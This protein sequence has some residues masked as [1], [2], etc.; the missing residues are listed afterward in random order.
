[1]IA[2][3]T[4][5]RSEEARV[6]HR[7]HLAEV[8]A[9]G[10]DDGIGR[11]EF[12]AHDPEV[13]ATAF[14]EAV[15]DVVVG[16]GFNQR[17]LRQSG[18]SNGPAGFPLPDDAAAAFAVREITSHSRVDG[19]CWGAEDLY[20]DLYAD[21]GAA[22]AR[23]ST[24]RPLDVF[25]HVRSWGPLAAA[26]ARADVDRARALVEAFEE[27]AAIGVFSFRFDGGMVDAPHLAR[28]RRLLTRAGDQAGD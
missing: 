23:D 8:F 27:H 5:V 3:P 19:T 7:R 9:T 1:M 18:A 12:P 24:G 13:S 16:P 22:S 11:G 25:A 4:P 14:V 17:V 2:E 26:A 20:A 15:A 10:I 6:A 28:G 21:L